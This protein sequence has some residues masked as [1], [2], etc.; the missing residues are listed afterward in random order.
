MMTPD[1]FDSFLTDLVLLPEP[2]DEDFEVC[3][4]C[5]ASDESGPG[6]TCPLCKGSNSVAGISRH[7]SDD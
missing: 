1:E 6:W 4:R 2:P 5:E 7:P 3:P